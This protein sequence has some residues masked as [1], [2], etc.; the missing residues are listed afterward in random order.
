MKPILAGILAL[1]IA[2]VSAPPYTIN[3]S[4]T[5]FVTQ[6]P[7]THVIT[8]TVNPIA[9]PYIGLPNTFTGALNDF[10][11][12]ML[13]LPGARGELQPACGSNLEGVIWYTPGSSVPPTNGV[14]QVC[15]NMSG[16]YSWQTP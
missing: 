7:A 14:T 12:T 8:L 11:E 5:V 13:M 9:I 1:Q 2:T 6:N 16:T 4:Q 3:Q 10:S 15:K